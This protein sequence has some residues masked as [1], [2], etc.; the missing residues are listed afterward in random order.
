MVIDKVV[1]WVG[2]PVASWSLVSVEETPRPLD[3]HD[4]V[5]LDQVVNF[6]TIFHE[7]SMPHDVEANHVF[8]RQVLNGMESYCSVMTLVYRDTSDVRRVDCTNHME[9]DG[10][11]TDLEGLS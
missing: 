11:P 3:H 5:A 7:D 9:M 6:N 4:Q 10:V 1:V 2:D 8:D